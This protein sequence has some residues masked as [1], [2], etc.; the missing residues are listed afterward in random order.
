MVAMAGE[1]PSFEALT[2]RLLALPGDEKR[3]AMSLI[4]NAIGDSIGLPFECR[5]GWDPAVEAFH[6]LKTPVARRKFTEYL[7]R[8]RLDNKPWDEITNVS[9]NGGAFLRTWSDDTTCCDLKMSAAAHADYLLKANLDKN[10]NDTLKLALYQQYLKWAH[11]AEGSLFQGTGGF[12][13][14]FLRPG[15][16][17]RSNAVA[18][19][20]QDTPLF[21]GHSGYKGENNDVAEVA[22]E[23]DWV[24]GPFWPTPEFAGFTSGYFQGRHGFPSWGNGAAMS[25][26]PDPVLA[27]RWRAPEAPRSDLCEAAALFSDSHLEPGA[28]LGSKLQRQLLE[29]VYAGRVAS[30]EDLKAVVTTLQVFEELVEYGH[31][32]YPIAPFREWLE[33]GDC[34]VATAEAFLQNMTGRSDGKFDLSVAPHG[35]FGAMLHLAGTY[36][37]TDY[38]FEKCDERVEPCRPGRKEPIMFSHRGL[39][40]VIIG[41]FASAGAAS[42]W[43]AFDRVIYAGGDTD[44]VGACAGQIACPFFD[45]AE[46]VALYCDFA[47]CCPS[48]HADC[49]E[50]QQAQENLRASLGWTSMPAAQLDLLVVANAAARRYFHRCLLFA[51]GDLEALEAYPS[52]LDPGFAGITSAGGAML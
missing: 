34:E 6:S 45:P 40:S 11:I 49:E 22:A 48:S 13:Q 12:T 52:L 3:V 35:V 36:E 31:E 19:A 17:G 7:V 24:H 27:S 47:A 2:T 29:E 10:A 25:F 33:K 5:A 32:S 4:G 43:E 14:D 16:R 21:H 39:N 8:D 15:F 41:I 26:A 44:T 42:L 30:T 38:S 1:E 46:V 9:K 50:A 20:M 18:K 23:A 28:V 51:A 37:H